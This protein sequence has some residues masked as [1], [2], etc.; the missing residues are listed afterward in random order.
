[1]SL[2]LV[3]LVLD[4]PAE[5]AIVQ[6]GQTGFVGHSIE[7]CAEALQHLLSAP[8]QLERMSGH[9]I[10][11]IADTRTPARS[12]QAFLDLWRELLCE[13]A[14]RHDFRCV[15]GD[16]PAEWFLATQRLPGESWRPPPAA[17][18]L[19]KPAKG[20]LGP[21]RKCVSTRPIS[22]PAC[23]HA[24]QRLMLTPVL[25]GIGLA[26]GLDGWRP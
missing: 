17:I 8:D 10:R 6:D 12:A 18:E 3:P 2:G 11:H 16:N 21:F 25:E 13:P 14:R 24:G 23:R 20:M 22:V 7:A 5:K 19:E 4:N 1:M 15:I 26:N 9:A